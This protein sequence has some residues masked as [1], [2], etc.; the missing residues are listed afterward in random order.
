MIYESTGYLYQYLAYQGYDL[1]VAMK[2]IAVIGARYIEFAF[3]MGYS[4]GLSEDTFSMEQ[5]RTLK[6]MLGNFGLKT[7]ALAAHMDLGLENAVSAFKTRMDFAKE[8]GAR[9]ILTNSSTQRNI[10]SQHRAACNPCRIDRDIH[11][12]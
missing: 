7:V 5:A 9:V 11:C 6:E 1:P 12:F 4:E 8:I 10:L 2:E 3:I